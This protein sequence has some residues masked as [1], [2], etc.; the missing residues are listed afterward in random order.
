MKPTQPRQAG[1]VQLLDRLLDKGVILQ[2][3]LLI[4]LAGVPLIGVSLR[5]AVAA[6]E[7]MLRYGIWEDWDEAV[8][9]VART[10]RRLAAGWAGQT[11]P[12]GVIACFP[13]HVWYSPK[14]GG[15]TP[16]EI[17]VTTTGLEAVPA[18]PLPYTRIKTVT[19]VWVSGAQR[20]GQRCLYLTLEDGAGL[21][22]LVDEVDGLRRLI[23]DRMQDAEILLRR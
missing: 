17:L 16:G 15:W 21:A 18:P 19:P 3:D 20:D 7:T 13:G 11:E 23:Q 5:A 10:S 4:S 12:E 6:V 22:L 14:T 2:A 1:L 9:A 8:R